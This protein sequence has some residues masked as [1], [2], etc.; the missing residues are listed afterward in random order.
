MQRVAVVLASGGSALALAGALFSQYVMG[1]APCVLCIYQR[2]PHL[3]AVIIGV[4]WLTVLPRRW[5]AVLGALAA[6]STAA[7]AGYHTGVEQLWWAGPSTCSGGAGLAGLSV[8]I[9]L[10]PGADVAA[11]VRC[12]EI[13]ARFAGLS[14][15]AWNMIVSLIFAGFWARAALR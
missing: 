14:M 8:D 6:L 9:L 3:A 13:A 1:L 4:I 11:P 5:L 15:A 10:D 2:W 12:D 7:V